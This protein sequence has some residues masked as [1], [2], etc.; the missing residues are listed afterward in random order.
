MPDYSKAGRLDFDVPVVGVGP[1]VVTFRVPDWSDM[2]A[3]D[4]TFPLL[5]AQEAEEQSAAESPTELQR[6]MADPVAHQRFEQRSNK[7]LSLCAV[8]PEIA[9]S[10]DPPAGQLPVRAIRSQ[11]RLFVF[12]ALV[13]LAGFTQQATAAI[14]PFAATVGSSS[15]QTPSP[16]GT[17][18]SPTPS[19]SEEIAGPTSSG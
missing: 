10:D 8:S 17:G 6:I 4:E 11:D 13:D 14:R 15:Q 1:V 16:D 9:L 5:P 19:S 18:N 3:C 2:A 12:L 7:M